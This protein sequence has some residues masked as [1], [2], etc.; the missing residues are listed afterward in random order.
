MIEKSKVFKILI[1]CFC[2]ILFFVIYIVIQNRF[3]RNKK[4]HLINTAKRYENK[5]PY[6]NS[7]RKINFRNV[8]YIGGEKIYI[9]RPIGISDKEYTYVGERWYPFYRDKDTGEIL[10]GY[11]KYNFITAGIPYVGIDKME[12]P[13]ERKTIKG[14]QEYVLKW[15]G[16]VLCQHRNIIKDST[17]RENVVG[18]F[19][20]NGIY[21]VYRFGRFDR[22]IDLVADNLWGI[23]SNETTDG[24]DIYDIEDVKNYKYSLGII[25]LS[26]NEWVMNILR[27]CFGFISDD[28]Y[29]LYNKNVINFEET[30]IKNVS[31]GDIGIYGDEE[32]GYHIGICIGY[33]KRNNPIF[34]ICTTDKY[35]KIIKEYIS[36]DDKING[37]N[38]LCI[39]NVNNID[40]NLFDR[41]Y[42]TYLPFSDNSVN[43]NDIVINDVSK[44]NKQVRNENKREMQKVLLDERIR[45]ITERER[46]A[47]EIRDKE[48]IDLG[49]YKN[50][51]ISTVYMINETYSYEYQHMFNNINENKNSEF[52]R[53][54]YDEWKKQEIKRLNDYRNNVDEEAFEL[55]YES[56]KDLLKE[57]IS[58]NKDIFKNK[59]EK[60]I[61]SWFYDEYGGVARVD[62]DIL[63][64]FLREN[65]KCLD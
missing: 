39:E 38:I 65:P 28:F 56:S 1:C 17:I 2:I 33:D 30:D 29:D 62:L 57:F 9:N 19:Y 50:I 64:R 21:D 35:L 26:P 48:N 53:K 5:E 43:T 54:T 60:D 12:V 47:K 41:Y 40:N 37:F 13:E 51:D 59:T 20:G 18:K 49:R 55:M 31:I 24:Y 36:N 25:E 11:E 42:K 22:P 7:N 14:F 16:S 6:F 32:I 58:A 45:R 8:E 52:H 23:D 61:E 44:Y 4:I 46:N 63:L 10:R 34:S 27:N 15:T 3:I